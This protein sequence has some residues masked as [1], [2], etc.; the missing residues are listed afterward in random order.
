M[1]I[2]RSLQDFVEI[3]AFQEELKKCK[4]NNPN[5]EVYDYLSLLEIQ[6]KEHQIL[7][8]QIYIGELKLN[9]NLIVIC[10]FLHF[11]IKT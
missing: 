6:M 3:F 11:W 7:I 9:L 5:N 2:S 10:L 4:K 1:V 8:D